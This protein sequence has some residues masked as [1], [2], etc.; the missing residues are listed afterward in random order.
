LEQ[1]LFNANV[2]EPMASKGGVI[3]G[4]VIDGKNGH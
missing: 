2:G 1:S 4:G 3:R